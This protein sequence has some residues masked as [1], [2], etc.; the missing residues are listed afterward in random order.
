MTAIFG[1]IRIKWKISATASEMSFR[2]GPLEVVNFVN[3]HRKFGQTFVSVDT[4]P[5]LVAILLV[6]HH[7]PNQIRSTTS[8]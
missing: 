1:S 5:S 2:I 4:R 3:C 6:S 7:C 8:N